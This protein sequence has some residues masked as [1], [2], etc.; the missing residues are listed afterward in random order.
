MAVTKM[1]SSTNRVVLR[2]LKIVLIWLFFLLYPYHGNESFKPI[3]LIGFLVLVF[4]VFLYNEVI[5]LH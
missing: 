4:G 5:I 3:Q 1:V 2:Q